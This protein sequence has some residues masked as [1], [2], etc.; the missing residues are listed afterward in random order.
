MPASPTSREAADGHLRPATPPPR[1][2][3]TNPQTQGTT[4]ARSN[5]TNSGD[6]SDSGYSRHGSSDG[7]RRLN[8]ARRPAAA[9][10][11]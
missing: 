3:S 11:G 9:R 8:S 4:A 6:N 10:A 7:P 2:A 1:A 5:Y